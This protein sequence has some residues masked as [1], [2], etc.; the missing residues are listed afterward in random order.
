M[1]LPDFL[2][3]DKYGYIHVADHRIGLSDIVY[4]YQDGWS[5]EMV[6][7]EFPTLPLPL[8]QQIIA[9]YLANRAEVDAYVARETAEIEKQRARAPQGPDLAELRQR[10]NSP[11]RAE[12][13]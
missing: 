9:F 10:Y 7:D 12:A 4:L 6:A 1:T 2:A 3:Q 11:R 13:K 8:V 5:A